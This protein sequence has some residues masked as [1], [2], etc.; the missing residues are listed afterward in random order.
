MNQVVADLE[1]DKD[2]FGHL[3]IRRGAKHPIVVLAEGHVEQADPGGVVL[4]VQ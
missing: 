1:D 3:W 2:N 4:C